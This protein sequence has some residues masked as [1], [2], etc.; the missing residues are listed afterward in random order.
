MKRLWLSGLL[1]GCCMAVQAQWYHYTPAGALQIP[2]NETWSTAGIAAYINKH[3]NSPEQKLLAAYTWINRNMEYNKD[4]MFYRYWGENPERKL[5][6]VLKTRKGVCENFAM[7]LASIATQC[8]IPAYTVNGYTK[9]GET[10]QWQGH[11]WCA[12]NLNDDW[13]FCD[14]TWDWGLKQEQPG[15]FLIA[16]ETLIATHMPFDPI[17][18]LLEKP[19]SHK[20]FRQG[21]SPAKKTGTSINYKDSIRAFLASD[22]LQ[23]MEAFSRRMK[24]AGLENENLRTWYAYNEM[25]IFI[26]Y[27]ERDMHLFNEAVHNLNQAK[28]HFNTF[29]Q[30]RNNGMLPTKTDQELLHNFNT[31]DSLLASIAVHLEAI[32]RHKENY[33][34]DTEGLQQ[35]AGILSKRVA[36]QKDFLKKYF[37]VTKMGK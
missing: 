10:V 37:A 30:F 13:F 28:Q 6:S 25:K 19:V 22:T 34:Y 15:Y 14:P 7:L 21:Y 32:G 23:Q 12:V 36:A 27:Q 20:A 33:Q 24:Q 3:F 29:I 2:E 9:I 4:S 26:V 11:S 18:Q 1:I 17:W 5:Q 35:S 31:I 16:P 8:G